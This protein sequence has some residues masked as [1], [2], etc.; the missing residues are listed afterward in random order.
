LNGLGVV[1][2]LN[3]EARTLGPTVKRIGDVSWL[4]DGTL[5]T[6]SGIGS[7]AAGRAA[8]RLIEAGASALMSFGLA[9]G[10]D[11][12][13]DAGSVVIPDI[14]V[15]PDGAGFPTS[16]AW[17]ERLAAD[18]PVRLTV[19]AGKLLTSARPIDAPADK[20]AAFQDTGAVAVDMESAAVAA[21]AAA[22]SLPFLAVRVIVDTAADALPRAVLAASRAGQVKIWPLLG[23]LARAPFELVALIRLAQRYRKAIR[24][25]AAVGRV[26]CAPSL[27]GARVA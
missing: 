18:L 24:S 26:I 23:G 22:H 4:G 19:A 6:L 7:A 12:K 2:A 15:S 10:L 14:V 27:A 21:V 16:A 17:R 5:L 8:A 25:L 13:L 1:A 3:A 9:G 11:P 20:R